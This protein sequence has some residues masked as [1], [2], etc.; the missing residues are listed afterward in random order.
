[1]TC[2]NVIVRNSNVSPHCWHTCEIQY[3]KLINHYLHAIITKEIRDDKENTRMQKIMQ[4]N[5]SIN[6]HMWGLNWYT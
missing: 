3:E 6:E 4:I 1:M 2:N 5:K